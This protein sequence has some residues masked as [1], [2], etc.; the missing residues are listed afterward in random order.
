MAQDAVVRDVRLSRT[1]CSELSLVGGG[2]VWV[3]VTIATGGCMDSIP[4]CA[5]QPRA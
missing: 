2:L 1:A 5:S 4:P 3:M